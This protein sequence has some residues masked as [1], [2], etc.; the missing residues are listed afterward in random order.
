MINKSEP[1]NVWQLK[2]SSRIQDFQIETGITRNHLRES[3]DYH[4]IST[5]TDIIV[6][7]IRLV[8]KCKYHR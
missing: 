4:N 2:E 3:N 6:S 5:T 7:R 8:C 1:W